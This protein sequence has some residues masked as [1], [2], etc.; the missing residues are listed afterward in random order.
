M[1][2][3]IMGSGR[4]GS[5]L[6]DMLDKEHH[7]VTILDWDP[8]A[9]SRLPDD[10]SGRTVVGNAVDQDVL[11][12]AGIESADVFVAATSGDN[13]NVMASQVAK[14]LFNVPRVVSRIKDPIRAEIYEEL[15]IHVDCRTTE[16]VQTLRRLL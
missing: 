15:G 8:N 6:A 16:G 12:A 2:I 5:L 13:R 1:R 4:T 14:Q 9:F 7:D 11:R 3:V 10:F